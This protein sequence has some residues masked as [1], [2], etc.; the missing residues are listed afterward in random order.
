MTENPVGVAES[1]VQPERPSGGYSRAIGPR[2]GRPY[3]GRAVRPRKVCRFCAYPKT[4]IDYKDTLLLRNFI[5]ERGKMLPRHITGVCAKHQ[6]KLQ[7]A[8]KRARIM[9]LLPFVT[10]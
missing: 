4:L 1:R 5:T 10:A 3:M 9:A 6:R 7:E 8:I 2:R